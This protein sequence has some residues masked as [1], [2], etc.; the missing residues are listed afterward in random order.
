MPF[1]ALTV[2]TMGR[3]QMGTVTQINQSGF[4]PG[5]NENYISAIAAITTIRASPG[6]KFFPPERNNTV[7]TPAALDKYFHLIHKQSNHR[8]TVLKKTREQTS[9]VLVCGVNTNHFFGFAQAFKGN[10]AINQGIK[11]IVPAAADVH[12]GMNP[13]ALLAYENA[14]R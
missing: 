9:R 10:L 5:G 13:G 12:T 6:Y 11:G 1:F 3:M 7:S 14:T 8:S 4:F 2:Y